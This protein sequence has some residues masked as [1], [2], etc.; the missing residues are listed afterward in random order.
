MDNPVCGQLSSNTSDTSSNTDTYGNRSEQTEANNSQQVIDEIHEPTGSNIEGTDIHGLADDRTDLE[1]NIIEDTSWQEPT[2]H[3]EQGSG[4]ASEN[5]ARDRQLLANVEFVE[6]RDGTGEE[7]SR[8]WQ[9]GI[10]DE[11]SPEI[12]EN[13]AGE[14]MH[15]VSTIEVFSQQSES[16]REE[17]AVPMLSNNLD[18]LEGSTVEDVNWHESGVQQWQ[19][20]VLESDERGSFGSN[21]WRDGIRDSIGGH[22]R[23]IIANEWLENEDREETSEVWHGV[24]GFQ[25][26]VQ[27]WLGESSDQEAVPVGRM[28][29]FYIP[30]DDNV[31]SMELRELLSRYESHY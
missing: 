16:N 22:Q 18:D 30:D 31:Y 12:I 24:G 28:D 27:S 3:L 10:D 6:T 15:L 21:E 5:E 4:N 2:A 23:E 9:Q 11:S 19:N 8:N 29:P 17:S 7:V 26:S 20:Q 14:Y 1:G 13:E 25:E